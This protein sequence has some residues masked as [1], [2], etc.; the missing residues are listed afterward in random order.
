M[1]SFLHPNWGGDT[2]PTPFEALSS[3]FPSQGSFHLLVLS[4]KGLLS[5]TLP[6]LGV[7]PILKAQT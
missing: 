4:L 5:P 6:L 1:N 2:P 3:P 7:F